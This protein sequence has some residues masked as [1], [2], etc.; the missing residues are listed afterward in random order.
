MARG[1]ASLFGVVDSNPPGSVSTSLSV[2]VFLIHAYD[3]IT[4]CVYFYE[5]YEE[6]LTGKMNC[7]SGGRRKKTQL[8]KKGHRLLEKVI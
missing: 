1:Q 2:S 5:V 3:G 4:P 8:G 7:C 6:H